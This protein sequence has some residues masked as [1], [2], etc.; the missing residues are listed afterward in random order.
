M[1]FNVVVAVTLLNKHSVLINGERETS[2]KLC[3]DF[4]FD[5]ANI[6]YHYKLRI[7]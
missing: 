3:F 2:L 6:H 5:I 7:A 4:V 1:G